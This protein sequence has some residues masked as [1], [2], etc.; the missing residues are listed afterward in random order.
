MG[1]KRYAMQTLIVKKVDMAIVVNNRTK[2][3]A[4]IKEE[5]S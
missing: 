4:G 2:S 1:E 5:S 3:I